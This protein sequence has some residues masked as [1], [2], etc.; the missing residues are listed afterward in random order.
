MEKM[1]NWNAW[2]NDK[3]LLHTCEGYPVLLSPNAVLG[4]EGTETST[5]IA[6][7]DGLYFEVKETVEEILGNIGEL[8]KESEAR[9]AAQAEE[10]RKQ[11]EEMMAAQKA[12]QEAS[13]G[14]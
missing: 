10:Q 5:N 1:N 12:E 7:V 8:I 11:Y 13:E 9:K 2:C 4:L 3:V 6:L 14:K